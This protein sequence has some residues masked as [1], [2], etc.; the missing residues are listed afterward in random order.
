MG[1]RFHGGKDDD[2]ISEINITPFV[3]VMLVLL[4]IFMVAAPMMTSSIDIEL[5]KTGTKIMEEPKDNLVVSLNKKGILYFND[6]PLNDKTQIGKIVAKHVNNDFTQKIYVKA[7]KEIFYGEV[8][9]IITILN[10][11]GF[12]QIILVT[13]HQDG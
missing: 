10:K 1:M 12:S 13:K 2:F 8:M 6:S 9:D 3:D 5:P 4:I 7:D 11:T